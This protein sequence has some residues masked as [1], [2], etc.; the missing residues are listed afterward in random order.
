MAGYN[1]YEF[2]F[3]QVVRMTKSN[4][5]HGRTDVHRIRGN[6][7]SVVR[8]LTVKRRREKMKR[9]RDPWPE[10]EQLN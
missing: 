2:S 10:P 7:S 4:F 5:I 8:T 9:D 1:R 3:L 6:D